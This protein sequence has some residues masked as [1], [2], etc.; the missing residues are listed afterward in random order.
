MPSCTFCEIASHQAPA[1]IVFEDSATVA[2]LDHRPL[3]PGHM[4]LIPHR[5][6]ANLAGLPG[7]LSG[8]LFRNA[9]LLALALET[10]LGAQGAFLALNNKVSQSVPHLHVHIVPRS[11][12]DGLRG[13]FWPRTRYRDD[14]HLERTRE[15]L[16]D[17]IARLQHL[18]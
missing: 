11:K 6:V 12:G 3:F 16:R 2:F 13:F 10:A 8:V 7:E 5:H 1:A 18:P 17:A 9:R 15:Q 4:L 14:A